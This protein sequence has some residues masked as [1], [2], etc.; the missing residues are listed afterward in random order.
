MIDPSHRIVDFD[1]D[2]GSAFTM[3]KESFEKVN[4]PV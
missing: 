4:V 3:L 2:E 1:S